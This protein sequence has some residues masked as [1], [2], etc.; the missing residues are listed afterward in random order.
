MNRE[1][2]NDVYLKGELIWSGDCG[3]LKRA[4]GE[5][6]PWVSKSLFERQGFKKELAKTFQFA[7]AA[8]ESFSGDKFE[9]AI[10]V[11]TT[12]LLESRTYKPI[13]NHFLPKIG[14]YFLL[15]KIKTWW[16]VWLLA[17]FRP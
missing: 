13:P 11:G 7:L 4:D 8:A 5:Y 17:K 10:W 14:G 1:N 9:D 16:L 6:V 12:M 3:F 2:I 15:P